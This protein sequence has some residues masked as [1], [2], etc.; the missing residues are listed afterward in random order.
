MKT[1]NQT[2]QGVQVHYNCSYSVLSI[3]ANKFVTWGPKVQ[4]VD[5][6]R[7]RAFEDYLCKICYVA[8]RQD[9][10]NRLETENGGDPSLEMLFGRFLRLHP[11][12]SNKSQVLEHKTSLAFESDARSA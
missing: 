6:L 9:F 10:R 2:N 5:N 11:V 7:V 4:L 3:C 1:N 8:Q 12:R